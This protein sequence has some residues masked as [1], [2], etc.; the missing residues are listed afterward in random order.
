MFLVV[1]LDGEDKVD[2]FA[3]MGVLATFSKVG[4]GIQEG[5]FEG[6]EEDLVVVGFGETRDFFWT[7]AGLASDLLRG[8]GLWDWGGAVF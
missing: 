7:D 3:A 5:S 1:V 2:G 8:S 4:L 6:K